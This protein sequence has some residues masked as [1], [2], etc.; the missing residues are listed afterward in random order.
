MEEIFVFLEEI[1]VLID[2]MN[3]LFNVVVL[4]VI[5]LIDMIKKMI[6]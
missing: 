5:V 6:E 1:I 4:I 3:N 2:E